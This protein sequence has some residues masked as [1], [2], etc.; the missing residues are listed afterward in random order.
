VEKRRSAIYEALVRKFDELE[1]ALL[2]HPI[3]TEQGRAIAASIE[4]IHKAAELLL[5]AEE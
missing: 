4:V 3:N 5:G 2:R 1:T